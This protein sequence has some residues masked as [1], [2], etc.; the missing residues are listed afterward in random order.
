MLCSVVLCFKYNLNLNTL[1]RAGEEL[2]IIYSIFIIINVLF[3]KNLIKLCC[4]KYICKIHTTN[5]ILEQVL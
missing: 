2:T 1:M 3:L 4:L 5:I